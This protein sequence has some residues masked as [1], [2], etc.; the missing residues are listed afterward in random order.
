MDTGETL[1]NHYI[2]GRLLV[3]LSHT[4]NENVVFTDDIEMYESFFDY[5]DF[6][7]FNKVALSVKM[8]DRL[9]LQL[10]HQLAFRNVPVEGFRPLDQTMMITFVA[11]IF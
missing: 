3:G 2:A 5:R 7:L 8:T 6:R 10:S 11:S 1:D 4:L 9:S